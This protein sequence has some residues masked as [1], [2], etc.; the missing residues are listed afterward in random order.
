MERIVP[1]PTHL[2]IPSKVLGD[3]DGVNKWLENNKDEFTE[4]T[5]IRRKA[6]VKK[7]ETV[8]QRNMEELVDGLY[9]DANCLPCEIAEKISVQRIASMEKSR[10]Q[11]ISWKKH[12]L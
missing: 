11:K 8:I 12:Q 1:T 9:K 6:A 3:Y 5:E 7:L 10:Q 4:L 2:E